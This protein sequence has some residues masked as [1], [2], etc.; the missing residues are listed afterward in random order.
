EKLLSHLVKSQLSSSPEREKADVTA[1]DEAL[2]N[3]DT[4]LTD[5]EE[6]ILFVHLPVPGG[7]VDTTKLDNVLKKTEEKFTNKEVQHLP[8]D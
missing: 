3:M 5:K 8:A 6:N 2:G 7:K 4:A 1:V